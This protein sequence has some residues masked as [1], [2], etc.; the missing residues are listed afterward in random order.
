MSTLCSF[1]NFHLLT[2]ALFTLAA[3]SNLFASGLSALPSFLLTADPL[4][5]SQHHLGRLQQLDLPSQ[6]FRR[7]LFVE[8][9][10]IPSGRSSIHT[11]S[12]ASPSTQTLHRTS[13]S[14]WLELSSLAEVQARKEL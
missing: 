2:L 8:G 9:V 3:N 4:L 7:R 11:L 6:L 14:V 12:I 1:R 13:S 10:H 5:P